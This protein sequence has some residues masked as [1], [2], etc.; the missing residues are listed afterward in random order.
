MSGIFSNYILRQDL[1]EESQS[2]QSLLVWLSNLFRDSLSFPLV[3][4]DYR[5]L[6]SLRF[7]V[8]SGNPNSG[9]HD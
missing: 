2:L 5:L 6:C 3:A 7:Y 9:P 4:C 1:S 8:S